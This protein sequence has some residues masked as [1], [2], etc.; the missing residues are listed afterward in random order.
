MKKLLLLAVLLFATPGLA[1]ASAQKLLKAT[2]AQVVLFG[3]IVDATDATAETGLTIED[4]DVLV[5]Q[6][7]ASCGDKSEATNLAHVGIG[8]YTLTLDAIDTAAEES[9]CVILEEAGTLPLMQCYEIQSAA[10]A[11]DAGTC[12]SGTTTTCVDAAAFTTADADYYAKGFA[13]MFTS[14]TLDKQSACIYAFDP[15]TDK[16]T[17]RPALTQAVS[18][19]TYVLLAHPTCGG[20][21]TP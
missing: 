19:H 13:I 6:D 21:T 17:F 11:F 10:L 2:A 7:S 5:C 16:V 12:D 1:L 20:V 18:T 8:V 14:G 9:V 15:A 3:P 4:S